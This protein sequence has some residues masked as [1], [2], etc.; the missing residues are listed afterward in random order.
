MNEPGEATQDQDQE[1]H[2]TKPVIGLSD[3][4]LLQRL[5]V[6]ERASRNHSSEWRKEAREDYDLVSGEQ[7]SEQDKVALLDEMRQ[8]IVFNRTAPMVDAVVGAEIL[9]RQ[10]VT[11]I[12]RSVGRVKTTELF[13]AADD[14]VRQQCDAEDE[15]SD[16]FTDAVI[17]GMGWTETRM[18]YDDNP[19]GNILIDRIDPLEIWWDPGAKKRNIVD[20]RYHVRRKGFSPDE[21]KNLFPDKYDQVGASASSMPEDDAFTDNRPP[22]DKYREEGSDSEAQRNKLI[23]VSHWQWWDME[24]CFTVQVPPSQGQPQGG[25]RSVSSEEYRQIVF[26][27]LTQGQQ[28]PSAVRARRKA[29]FE[30]F[31]SGYVVLGRRRLDCGNFTL[32]FITGKRDR[33]KN[34]WY[35]ML[36]ALRDP[37][38]WANKWL[39][40]ILHIINH[41]AKGGL[42]YE[43][44]TFA[45]PQKA[46]EEWSRPDSMT[47]VKAGALSQNKLQPKPPA[48]FPAGHEKLLEFAITS[49]AQVSGVNMELLGLVE[50][51]Q[52]GVLE[53]QRKRSGY[54]I[55]AV[56]FDSLRRYRKLQARTMLHYIQHYISDGRL[57]KIKGEDGYEQYVPLFR[58]A[59]AIEYDV[60]VDEAPMSQNQK[61]LVWGMLLQMLPMLKQ[62]PIP[63][64]VWGELIK[65]SPLPSSVG[66]KLAAAISQPNPQQEQIKQQMAQ[67]EV[68]HKAAQVQK[69]HTAGVLNMAR[70]HVDM[71]N[72]HEPMT[73]TVPEGQ[74]DPGNPYAE[75]QIAEASMLKAQSG[76]EKDHAAAVASIARARKDH[77]AAEIMPF[78]AAAKAKA[79]ALKRTQG[80][81]ANG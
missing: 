23:Y 66:D 22:Y 15:E 18:S 8:P 67:L 37:Q 73:P 78:E 72:A 21:F 62:A 52:P 53:Q 34:T 55:L 69:D 49:M 26:Q 2:E 27:S 38:R 35:G 29:Y 9:N 57:I 40:Q 4:D 44:G 60:I 54:A 11:F 63:P 79:A 12:P 61:D 45:N 28:P 10:T 5:K 7:W 3:D 13:T 14:W 50:R 17:C 70:A 76:A 30:A 6:W 59:D 56:Y 71:R 36:R 39:S 48:T 65:Y 20:R 24:D 64:Q 25:V 77:V 42:I 80:Q 51:D 19:E 75:Q 33:N 1:E 43:S 41:N 58:Q 68:Q 16:S 46:F 81:P 74:P 31:I 32:H 47:E